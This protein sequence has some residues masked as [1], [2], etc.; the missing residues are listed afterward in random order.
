MID[1]I[2]QTSVQTLTVGLE[3]RGVSYLKK[4]V[5]WSELI[6]APKF[7]ISFLRLVTGTIV[8]ASFGYLIGN[9]KLIG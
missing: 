3:P 7:R 4:R 1:S 2:S 5:V 9:M 8:L 6:R